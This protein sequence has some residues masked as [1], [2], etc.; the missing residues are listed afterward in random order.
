M[1]ELGKTWII[2]CMIQL[3][4]NVHKD[5]PG[6]KSQNVFIQYFLWLKL[7][8]SPWSILEL[9]LKRSFDCLNSIKKANY[10]LV[11]PSTSPIQ[12]S[13]FFGNYFIFNIFDIEIS[14]LH[15]TALNWLP[16]EKFGAQATVHSSK[17]TF[18]QNLL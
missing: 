16:N 3:F 1:N 8:M 14:I 6:W 12:K 7:S 9:I 11:D 4:E 5:F 15:S 13:E 2:S 18:C 10:C 17:S